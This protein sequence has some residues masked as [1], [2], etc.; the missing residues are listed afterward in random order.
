MILF[1]ADHHFKLGQKNVPV[2]WA[3]D[4]YK[5]FFQIIYDLEEQVDKHI[6]GGDLFDRKPSLEELE[7]Y[8][9]FIRN[10]KVETEFFDGNHEATKRNETFLEAL[11]E[12]TT[13]INPLVK[14]ITETTCNGGYTILPYCDL[15]KKGSIEKC[16][17]SLPLFTHVRGEIPPHVKP[18]VDLERFKDFPVVY[19]GDLHS[20]SNTQR[21]LVYPGSPMTIGFHRT[22]VKTGGLLIEDNLL[23]WT[24]EEFELPQLIRK[25]VSS[26]EEMLPTEYD[27][28][29]YELEG[30]ADDLARVS[31][32]EL[33][34][35][36][37]ITRNTK[38][39]L[40]LRK[41]K[42]IKEELRIY[43]VEVQNVDP[44]RADRVLE[45]FDD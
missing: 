36:K 9:N 17:P 23:D 29:I 44:K 14:I 41:A 24:W 3:R 38:S 5:K 13:A 12:V 28:T 19:T 10:I 22:K 37:V 45:E 11:K 26:E 30:T 35:K 25:T 31:K 6:I 18:E 32:S 4:R 42:T 34:D 16:D 15:H 2:G 1:T 20:H 21:N 39:S 40:D 8:F 7:L 43:L 27:H 33:L